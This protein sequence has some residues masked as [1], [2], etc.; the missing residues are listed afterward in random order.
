M[1]K[2]SE[3]GVKTAATTVMRMTA[4]RHERRSRAGVTTRASSKD[5]RTTGNS[6]VMPN[7]PSS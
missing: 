5:T 3:L 7:R 2:G 1:E 6:K 4:Q